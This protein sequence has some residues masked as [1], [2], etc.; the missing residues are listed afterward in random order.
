MQARQRRQGDL[1][2]VAALEDKRMH[3]LGL[4][5]AGAAQARHLLERVEQPGGAL[6]HAAQAR[7]RTTLE[8]PCEVGLGRAVDPLQQATGAREH[9][10][11]LLIEMALLEL[12]AQT[13]I[14]IE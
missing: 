8:P 4:V 3:R 9:A 12:S 7:G 10:R 2:A 6:A 13:G 1:E 5:L 11:L 14:G